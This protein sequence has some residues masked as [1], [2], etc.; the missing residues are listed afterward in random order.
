MIEEVFISFEKQTPS[1]F[2]VHRVE[3]VCPCPTDVTL[4]KYNR[5]RSHTNMS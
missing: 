4:R 1:A 3:G 2:L 5:E